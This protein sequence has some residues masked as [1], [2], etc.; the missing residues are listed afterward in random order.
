MR[1]CV[2]R[3]KKYMNA[4]LNP[5]DFTRTADCTETKEVKKH[6]HYWTDQSGLK[7]SNGHQSGLK[8]VSNEGSGFFRGQISGFG[9][10][11]ADE[12]VDGI[13]NKIGYNSPTATT[14]ITSPN[15]FFYA[16]PVLALAAL[17]VFKCR[18]RNVN[19]NCNG[20]K[21]YN[22]AVRFPN[23]QL[24]SVKMVTVFRKME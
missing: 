15:M 12:V 21:N 19:G 11:V 2:L 17:A 6:G 24:F 9:G 16:V 20:K 13:P 7:L 14:T 22:P 23:A 10:K 8:L 3:D 1:T 4:D 18:K 5:H